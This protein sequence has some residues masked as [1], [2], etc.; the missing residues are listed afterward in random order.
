VDFSHLLES[1]N[2]SGLIIGEG[3]DRERGSAGG[4]IIT[5]I[6]HKASQLLGNMT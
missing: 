1:L 3:A 4:I 6:C 5:Y 2:V